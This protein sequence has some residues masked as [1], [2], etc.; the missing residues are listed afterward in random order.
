MAWCKG[1]P[2]CEKN[3]AS[4]ARPALFACPHRSAA[5]PTFNRERRVCWNLWQINPWLF[6]LLLPCLALLFLVQIE[7][8]LQLLVPYVLSSSASISSISLTS[9]SLTFLVSVPKVKKKQGRLSD[10]RGRQRRRQS[11]R[12]VFSLRKRIYSSR[13]VIH[14][15]R[16][17]MERNGGLHGRTVCAAGADLSVSLGSAHTVQ[18]NPT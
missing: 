13:H 15:S 3:A 14:I 12:R 10:V 5:P 11:I 7:K 9:F 2:W 16:G 17:G 6:Y 4:T 18:S 1:F 8:E